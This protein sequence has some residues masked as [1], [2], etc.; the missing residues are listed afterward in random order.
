VTDPSL[1]RRAPTSGRPGFAREG[2]EFVLTV[3]DDGIS[4][5][6]EGELEGAPPAAPAR[7][8]GLG[9]RLL[10][11]LAA[12]LRGRF[13]RHVGPCGRGTVAEPRFAAAKPGS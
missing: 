11:A 2:S 7:G 6:P 8:S 1:R 3:A 4:L 12:Q 9:S 5:P 13:A 10:R